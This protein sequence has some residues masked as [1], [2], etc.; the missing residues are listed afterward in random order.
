MIDL[1]A[2]RRFGARIAEFASRITVRRAQAIVGAA[3]DGPQ[4]AVVAYSDGA[5]TRVI[6]RFGELVADAFPTQDAD[7]WAVASIHRRST[8]ATALSLCDY[9]PT[10]QAPRPPREKCDTA[11][12]AFM[13]AAAKARDE[14][15]LAEPLAVCSRAVLEVLR[16]QRV[17]GF[18]GQLSHRSLWRRLEELAAG[19][20]D[21]VRAALCDWLLAAT[22]TTPPPWEITRVKLVGALEPV[23]GSQP[24]LASREYLRE[25]ESTLQNDERS[26]AR[27]L[28]VPVGDRVVTIRLG[29]IA[30][31]KGRT[32]DAT[33]V[34]QTKLNQTRDVATALKVAAGIDGAPTD[35]TP[36]KL[37]AVTNVFVGSTRP[38]RLL[39]LAMPEADL[40]K[41]LRA[42]VTAWGWRI[43]TC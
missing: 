8:A 4:P 37:K 13:L 35:G 41:K 11:H 26:R 31:V 38:R 21:R 43:V 42:A 5:S 27:Q 19:S 28:T 34:V 33:L 39:C 17:A 29:S 23:I 40:S 36:I 1:G 7:A 18:E 22:T 25:A 6:P 10:Y 2:S 12:G 3:E 24:T 15:C 9:H 20:A 30:S 16:R 32:H 14:T